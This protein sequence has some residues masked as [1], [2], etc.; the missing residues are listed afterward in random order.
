MMDI[1]KRIIIEAGKFISGAVQRQITDYCWLK[2]IY[3][4]IYVDKGWITNSLRVE[5]RGDSEKIAALQSTVEQWI[6]QTS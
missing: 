6:K 1:E 3:C 4:Y 2:N 5:L